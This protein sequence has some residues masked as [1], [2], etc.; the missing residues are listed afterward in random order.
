VRTIHLLLAGCALLPLVAQPAAAA[1]AH[2]HHVKGPTSA[3]LAARLDAL[4]AS[5]AALQARVDA[6]TTALADTKAAAAKADD[7]AASA[8]K[9]VTL[10]QSKIDT[11]PAVAAAAAKAAQPKTDHLYYKGLSL[12]LGGYVD[13]TGIYRSRNQLADDTSTFSKLPFANNP[14]HNQD[15][16]RL[17]GRGSRVSLKAEGDVSRTIHLSGYGEID[18][19]GAAQTANNNETSSYNPRIRQGWLN[20]DFADAGI[21]VLAGDGWSLATLNNSGIKPLGEAIPNVLEYSYMPG[22]IYA[23]QGEF[24]L[25][26]RFAGGLT[27]AGAVENPATLVGG[28][29]PTKSLAGD[30]LTLT[31]GAAGGTAFNSANTYTL[32]SAPDVIVKAAYDTKL[33]ERNV[34]LEAFGLYRQFED[35]VTRNGATPAATISRQ[36]TEGGA[37]GV[38]VFA[39]LVPKMLD[40]QAS[41]AS[42]AG[43]GRYAAST[44]SDVTYRADGSLKPLKETAWMVGLTWKPTAQ[45]E[46]YA[47]DGAEQL[48]ASSGVDGA[49]KAFGY[50]SALFNNAQCF[51]IAPVTGGACT[52]NL[53]SVSQASL[54]IWRK[55][56]MGNF[57]R[58]QYG[59]SYSYTKDRTFGGIG[60]A[61]TVDE[62]I[63]MTSIRYYPF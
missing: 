62:N 18:F 25:T 33:G 24:R 53:K 58:F 9:A 55:L 32:H 44:L 13:M 40:L 15:E 26:K 8:A 22:F 19:L 63:I 59:L 10:A 11:M 16:T 61:P 14:L 47:Y 35:E 41:F 56:Y 48:D 30:A 37:V 39:N 60:G 21:S 34:H 2:K 52:A 17:S 51:T 6:L 5:N 28:T 46:L 54:G 50:G 27:V 1:T 29:A 4:A 57:G 31:T 43:I 12:T 42:G 20:V 38:G 45:W 7:D 3:E 49:G 23:R 36:T